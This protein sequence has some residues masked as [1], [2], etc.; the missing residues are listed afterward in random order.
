M[1]LINEKHRQIRL[2]TPMTANQKIYALIKTDGPAR[3]RTIRQAISNSLI[4]MH[5]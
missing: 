4:A 5:Q 2:L 3:N 1:H